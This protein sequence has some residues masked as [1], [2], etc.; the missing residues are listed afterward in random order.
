M[1]NDWTGM[2]LGINEWNTN[3]V[4]VSEKILLILTGLSWDSLVLTY[5]R[6]SLVTRTSQL[7]HDFSQNCWMVLENFWLGPFSYLQYF[8][9]NKNKHLLTN[10]SFLD[11]LL[12]NQCGI[13][14]FLYSNHLTSYQFFYAQQFSLVLLEC[15]TFAIIFYKS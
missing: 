15:K 2:N 3:L 5:L 11:W 6:V 13:K 12:Q 14:Q 4:L 7:I 8:I 10:I 1:M 9:R